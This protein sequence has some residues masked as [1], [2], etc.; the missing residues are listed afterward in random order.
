MSQ[1]SSS[2][3][4]R[5]LAS[6]YGRRG[7]G[8]GGSARTLTRARRRPWEAHGAAEIARIAKTR[9]RIASGNGTYRVR[10]LEGSLSPF[11]RLSHSHI[12]MGVVRRV[13]KRE[14][15]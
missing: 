7:R 10:W 15:F 8:A 2:P 3:P 14:S 4:I 12:S 1:E 5:P 6:P 11:L 9:A 13:E